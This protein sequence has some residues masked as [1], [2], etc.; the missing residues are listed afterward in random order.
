MRLRTI[1]LASGALITATLL[2]AGCAQSNDMGGMPG[3]D[4][5]S[6]P[7]SPT[8]GTFNSADEMFVTMMIPHHEQ[9][10]QMA[11][12]ILGKDG[13]DPRVT[14]LAQQIK[15]AQGPEITTMASWLKDWGMPEPSATGG[16]AGMGQGDGMMSQDDMAALENATGVDAAR[17]FLTGMISHHQGAIQMAKSVIDNG[18]DPKVAALAKKI[19]AS[20][21][22]E[23]TTMQSLLGSL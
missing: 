4:N 5:G 15:D 23:I 9:A 19:S 3:M 13:I 20:Q 17:L 12:V 6:M 1:A 14:A 2:L 16:M 18:Q 21:S 22:A 11:D 10:I 7:A 8:A